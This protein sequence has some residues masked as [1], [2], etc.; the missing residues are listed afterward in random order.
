MNLG[1]IC[2]TKDRFSFESGDPEDIKSEFLSVE[3]EDELLSGLRDAGHEVIRI[4]D[5]QHLLVRPRHWR[6]RCE[7]VFNR[8]TGY[9]GDHRSL[10]TP[11]ILEAAGIP[12]VGSD[13]YVHG[14]VRNKYHTKL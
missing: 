10:L 4:R 5:A 11:A 8:S 1:L 2:E 7:L 12:Y 13:P 14:L 6:K 9:R 3:E